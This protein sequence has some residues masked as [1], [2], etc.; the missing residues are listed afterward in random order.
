MFAWEMIYIYVKKHEFFSKNIKKQNTR[1]LGLI[2]K[3]I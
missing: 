1:L 2:S 3:I